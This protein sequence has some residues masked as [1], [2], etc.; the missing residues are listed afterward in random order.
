MESEY[1]VKISLSK[2]EHDNPEAPYYW[3][4]IKHD[5]SWHQIA[6]GWEDSP[7]KCFHAAEEYYRSLMSDS[8]F[9]STL[10]TAGVYPFS[11]TI[12]I[13]RPASDSLSQTPN[14]SVSAPQ[15]SL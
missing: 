3:R 5:R 10:S 14:I 8:G 11:R 6:F 13:I 12:S 1:A 2:H 7:E 9:I 15:F 4:L